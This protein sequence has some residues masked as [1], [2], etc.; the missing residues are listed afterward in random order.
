MLGNRIFR[1]NISSAALALLLG[2]TGP[3]V[4]ADTP[5][6]VEVGVFPYLSTRALLDLY[7]P[8]RGFLQAGLN[9]PTNLFTAPSFKAFA[10][11][12]QAGGYDVVMMPPHL[13]R[14]AQ[15]EA[16]YVP[17]TMFTR[18][19]R[20]VVV[21]AKASPIQTLKDLKGMRVATP[22]KIALVSIVG[23]QLLRDN[24]LV[25]D[26]NV[27]IHDAGSHSNAVLAVQRNEAEAAIT[28]NAALQQMPDALRNSVRVIAQTQ[29][30]PHVM[31]LAHPRLGQ[32]GVARVRELLLQFANTTEGR[33]F[34]KSSGFEGIRPV[35]E[36]DM[37][38]IDPLIKELKR[39]LETMPP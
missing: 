5:S 2:W 13:A 6:G 20:G 28:E 22:N 36:A 1:L 7:E 27:S 16:G 14:L 19:L 23:S 38:S 31:F 18:E 33:A 24:G 12:T 9:R 34:L 15:Q 32:A 11:R 39:I 3:A 29:R 8:V 10:D 21:V 26:A 25:N 35:D 4:A 17:L 30:L 37:K